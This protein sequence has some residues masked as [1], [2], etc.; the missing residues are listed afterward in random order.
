MGLSVQRIVLFFEKKVCVLFRHTNL[1]SFYLSRLRIIYD[2]VDNSRG[3]S[4]Y[5]PAPHRRNGSF[6]G[7]A[8]VSIFN[9]NRGEGQK[10]AESINLL[11]CARMCDRG[12]GT[13]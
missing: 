8:P 9:R 5:I 12:G 11:L 4:L 7:F 6:F 10:T 3:L 2:S 13:K 1:C